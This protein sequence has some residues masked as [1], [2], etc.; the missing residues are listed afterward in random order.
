VF[1]RNGKPIDMMNCGTKETTIREMFEFIVSYSYG[2]DWR[3]T[4]PPE[5]NLVL[6]TFLSFGATTM[7]TQI[8]HS[9]DPD[10]MYERFRLESHDIAKEIGAITDQ[11]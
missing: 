2:A 4:N 10:A 9:D 3:T 8:F 1:S 5:L 6:L 7:L 11:N